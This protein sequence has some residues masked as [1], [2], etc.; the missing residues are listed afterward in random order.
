VLSTLADQV[1][2]AIENNRLYSETR[3]ALTE[4]QTLHGQYLSQSWAK[5]AA[6]RQRIGYLIDQG[7]LL[8]MDT[9]QMPADSESIQENNSILLFADQDH[10]GYSSELQAPINVR[11]QIIGV[12][13]LSEREPGY[14]WT[15]E[16]RN[17]VKN[18]VD[19]IG[20]ALENARLIEQTQRRA[21]REHLVA[22]ISTKLRSSN[23][24]QEILETA[25]REI[26]QALKVRKAEI[27]FPT[28]AA[29]GGSISSTMETG[30]NGRL[31][32]EDPDLE[33]E[34]GGAE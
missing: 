27:I 16:E 22:E 8:P 18:I 25:R 33:T 1:A 23:D 2:I 10:A 3:K 17:L 24:A 28:I 20:L 26:Q 14:E 12:L 6:E 11:G 31:A 34:L 7:R 19:Q 32:D 4:L 15:D 30:G 5:V 9:A 21:E 29:P 13:N